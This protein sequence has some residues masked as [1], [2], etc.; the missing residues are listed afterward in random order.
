MAAE[1]GQAGVHRCADETPLDCSPVGCRMPAAPSFLP[2]MAPQV[3]D[4][5]DS[6]APLR[7]GETG[8]AAAV[9]RHLPA[10]PAG[11]SCGV[12]AVQDA[13]GC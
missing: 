5:I 8:S 11:C 12:A 3:H 6:T 10:R 2:I 13:P 7:R 4:I 9:P 1:E